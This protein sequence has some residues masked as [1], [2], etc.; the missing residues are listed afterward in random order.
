[1]RKASTFLRGISAS[2]PGEN[3]PGQDL[4][5]VKRSLRSVQWSVTPLFGMRVKRFH[6]Y[7]MRGRR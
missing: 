7:F 3:S 4:Q 2:Q 6:G 1:M 5:T